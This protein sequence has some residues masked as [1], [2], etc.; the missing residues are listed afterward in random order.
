MSDVPEA[1]TIEFY[2]P[3]VVA[4]N[5]ADN[6]TV[7]L[8]FSLQIVFRVRFD[9]SISD[10]VKSGDSVSL[11]S[12]VN[13]TGDLMHQGTTP[14]CI[15]KRIRRWVEGNFRAILEDDFLVTLNAEVD[16]IQMS[17]RGERTVGAVPVETIWTLKH[18]VADRRVM[19]DLLK[20]DLGAIFHSGLIC[21]T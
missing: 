6:L 12:K 9:T 20:G 8:D 2:E 1:N 4:K 5:L 19:T 3:H 10:L 21:F 17:F 7:Y 11:I 14:E 18:H 16:G 15:F 13:S